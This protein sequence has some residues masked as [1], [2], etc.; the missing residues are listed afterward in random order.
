MGEHRRQK[1]KESEGFVDQTF[2]GIWNL[3]YYAW[4]IYFSVLFIF[5]FYA[6]V[7]FRDE[8]R[9]VVFADTIYIKELNIHAFSAPDLDGSGFGM[10]YGKVRT[11]ADAE[12]WLEKNGYRSKEILTENSYRIFFVKPFLRN[13]ETSR[14]ESVVNLLI[15]Y[16][17]E[18]LV[19]LINS[20]EYRIDESR[21]PLILEE[22]QNRTM[23]EKI[24]RN[25]L[26]FVE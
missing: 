1:M 12:N 23:W 15:D 17:D 26:E 6:Y 9:K 18:K 13:G 5:P 25:I 8:C 14:S 2:R 20:R 7:Y 10:Y 22:S 24:N 4:V 11:I 19:D 3:I 16:G 21:F